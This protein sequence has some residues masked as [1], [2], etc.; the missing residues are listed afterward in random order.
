MKFAKRFVE[1]FALSIVAILSCFDRVIFKGYLPFGDDVSIAVSKGTT[2]AAYLGPVG[3][4][5]GEA[6]EVLREVVFGVEM[7]CLGTA[8]WARRQR[9]T[10]AL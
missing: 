4:L 2:F 10:A 6:F 8:M 7:P 5:R 9:S 1:K 3:W